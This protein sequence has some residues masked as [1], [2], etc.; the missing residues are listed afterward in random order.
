MRVLVALGLY[1]AGGV[2]LL[3]LCLLVAYLA[4]RITASPLPDLA[5]V[6]SQAGTTGGPPPAAQPSPVDG[7]PS[8]EAKLAPAAAAAAAANDRDRERERRGQPHRTL[9][10]SGPLVVTR[11]WPQDGVPVL[12]APHVTSS[13]SS[14]T[15]ASQPSASK[16]GILTRS[17]GYVSAMYRGLV[18]SDKD[19]SKSGSTQSRS[20]SNPKFTS[21]Y[22][23]DSRVAGE[24]D[25]IPG[26]GSGSGPGS[27]SGVG[28]G[29]GL[30]SSTSTTSLATST[31]PS[32]PATSTSA[33]PSASSAYLPSTP[34]KSAPATKKT[35]PGDTSFQGVLKESILYLYRPRTGSSAP[36]EVYAA[37]DLRGTRVSIYGPW[38]GDA[39]GPVGPD[40]TSPQASTSGIAPD[41]IP[42]PSDPVL[43]AELFLRRNAVRIVAPTS[44]SRGTGSKYLDSEEAAGGGSEGKRGN[45]V[46]MNHLPLPTARNEW[47]VFA[48]TAPELEDWYFAL[49]RASLEP[50]PGGEVA[51]SY[52]RAGLD[53]TDPVGKA[54]SRSD[55]TDLMERLDEVP[56]PLPLRWFNALLGRYWVGI[57]R[58]AW[59]EQVFTAKLKRKLAR[60][61]TPTFLGPVE[62]VQFNLGAAPPLFGRPMLK[63]LTP[64]GEA[65]MEASVHYKG[66][67]RVVIA[68][69]LKL[70][71]PGLKNPAYTYG[72][73]LSLA[74][75]LRSLEG[76]AMFTIKPPPTNRMWWAFTQPPQMDFA[77]IPG[78]SARQV[79]WAL[80]TRTIE[81]K[82]KELIVESLVFPHM[83]DFTFF[84]TTDYAQRGGIWADA[85]YGP[86]VHSETPSE[87]E[88]PVTGEQNVT[89]N[90]AVEQ[91]KGPVDSKGKPIP[92]PNGGSRATSG[93]PTPTPS[94]SGPTVALTNARDHDGLASS[95]DP[96][97]TTASGETMRQRRKPSHKK[98]ST[99]RSAAASLTDVLAR[100]DAAHLAAQMQRQSLQER[101]ARSNGS[102]PR[103]SSIADESI[104][105]TAPQTDQSQRPSGVTKNRHQPSTDHDVELDLTPYASHPNPTL[106]QTS[107]TDGLAPPLVSDPTGNQAEKCATT[108]Q[109]QGQLEP[110]RQTPT[111]VAHESDPAPMRY[112]TSVPSNL[113]E[114]HASPQSGN[115]PHSSLDHLPLSKQKS[116]ESLSSCPA[117]PERTRR[118][119]ECS[120]QT[121][122]RDVKHE[123]V[124]DAPVSSSAE[125]ENPEDSM[126]TP[127]DAAPLDP[128]SSEPWH[129]SHS[130]ST[131][132]PKG[133]FPDGGRPRSW[134]GVA[135]DGRS[136]SDSLFSTGRQMGEQK[137]KG[138]SG[139]D[140]I[141]DGDGKISGSSSG[142]FFNSWRKAAGGLAAWTANRR[143]V[144]SDFRPTEVLA[145]SLNKRR[146]LKEARPSGGADSIIVSESS[147]DLSND[148]SAAPFQQDHLSSTSTSLG[149][150]HGKSINRRSSSISIRR[151]HT[152]S[153]PSTGEGVSGGGLDVGK[154]SSGSAAAGVKSN[155][156]TGQDL[157]AGSPSATTSHLSGRVPPLEFLPARSRATVGLSLPDMS[158][159]SISLDSDPANSESANADEG[160]HAEPKS[161]KKAPESKESKPSKPQKTGT[162]AMLSGA[163]KGSREGR[164][165]D[166]STDI[167]SKKPHQSRPRIPTAYAPVENTD[168]GVFPA[169]VHIQPQKSPAMVVPGGPEQIK[170]LI[171]SSAVPTLEFASTDQDIDVSISGSPQSAP[172][173]Y[174][175][176]AH[177]HESTSSLGER[178]SMTLPQSPGPVMPSLPPRA[179]L[180]RSPERTERPKVQAGMSHPLGPLH[181]TLR[182]LAASSPGGTSGLPSSVKAHSINSITPSSVPPS[183]PSSLK[184]SFSISSLSSPSPGSSS[185]P[186]SSK[187][188]AD[189]AQRPKH[190]SSPSLRLSISSMMPYVRD[191]SATVSRTTHEEEAPSPTVLAAPWGAL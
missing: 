114:A 87:E 105:L 120:S 159:S 21:S 73:P 60:V 187:S 124:H 154:G 70:G 55:M 72:V 1:L 53:P 116:Q 140:P 15:S 84:D 189:A 158:G 18:R 145:P 151:V 14:S 168:D 132:Q 4:F 138:A 25:E 181:Q 136:H 97:N 66:Q 127:E 48:P 180:A 117:S 147:D 9:F 141:D 100:N 88:E 106:P 170:P 35:R 175:N 30:P 3:P 142:T 82:I 5:P 183:G 169:K 52:A 171:R 190:N 41:P 89:Q 109:G 144:I 157:W 153:S 165:P 125:P 78:V 95:I 188:S 20:T 122:P 56:D 32:T 134:L 8:G 33:S 63:A 162:V 90:P 68:T 118:A 101:E 28:A 152:S 45:G 92:I 11:S 69:V 39:L 111:T 166:T 83:D 12:A 80:V 47:F 143:S 27:G 148:L 99:P 54:F 19:R 110:G 31:I 7:S 160:R 26:S 49:F 50:P 77:I 164:T 79:Q 146:D 36:T 86:A 65:S 119:N 167:P 178:P 91:Y 96:S 123:A 177:A 17:G 131:Q 108:L 155:A 10:R 191:Y 42:Q 102:S 67:M 74:V 98:G 172:Q 174:G 113:S 185:D 6:P 46:G 43:D 186:A 163:L 135:S 173:D 40:P 13:M 161:T 64:E 126:R 37:I 2:T 104:A 149:R 130:A 94:P 59:I 182:P 44:C 24:H 121:V 107:S 23:H 75:E 62:V 112:S 156:S 184:P 16:E 38:I 137:S 179:A 93:T 76:N 150:A 81:A 103:P 128:N 34:S 51:H 176:A 129:Q 139:N 58:T 57:C 22:S 85:V 133:S 29:A 115:I 61:K 71:L